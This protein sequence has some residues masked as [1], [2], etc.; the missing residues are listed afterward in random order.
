[1]PLI[2]EYFCSTSSGYKSQ[3]KI[4]QRN[5]DGL[6]PSLKR[7]CQIGKVNRTGHSIL[8]RRDSKKPFNPNPE[9]LSD[10]ADSLSR[11]C[12]L[13]YLLGTYIHT[14]HVPGGTW[15]QATQLFYSGMTSVLKPLPPLFYLLV[16]YSP[17]LLYVDPGTL[18]NLTDS[19][20]STATNGDIISNE[21]SPCPLSDKLGTSGEAKDDGTWQ[22]QNYE[23][24]LNLR[25]SRPINAPTITQ[26]PCLMLQQG[27]SRSSLSVP[28]RCYLHGDCSND[29]MGKVNPA[30]AC[31]LRVQCLL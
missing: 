21:K 30:M 24:L 10:V 13:R 5:G 7:H 22:W 16:P 4:Y 25:C 23:I 15:C 12:Q 31:F 11:V 28:S 26:C 27:E 8:K 6:C 29:A 2:L 19:R 1:M 9:A 3:A 20:S 14:V 17:E 18:D